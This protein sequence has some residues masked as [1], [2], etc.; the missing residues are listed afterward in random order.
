[1]KSRR[2]AVGGE[3]CLGTR[4]RRKDRGQQRPAEGITDRQAHRKTDRQT[5]RVTQRDCNVHRNGMY[6]FSG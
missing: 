6:D 4:G 1:M 3:I 5:D 2:A